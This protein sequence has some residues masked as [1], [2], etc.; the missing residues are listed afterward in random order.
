MPR[1]ID[2]SDALA[3]IILKACA[4]DPARRIHSNLSQT[5][6]GRYL[7]YSFPAEGTFGLRPPKQG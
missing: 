6:R 4:F 2:V 3:E 5:D 1:P 7:S